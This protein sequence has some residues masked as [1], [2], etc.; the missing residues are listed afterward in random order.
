MSTHTNALPPAVDDDAILTLPEVAGILRRSINTMYWWR[1]QGEGPPLFKMG[2]KLA[3]TV[4]DLRRWIND[5]KTKDAG[6]DA[7]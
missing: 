7:A 2:R 4:G 1:Q 5:Q 3:I 6:P